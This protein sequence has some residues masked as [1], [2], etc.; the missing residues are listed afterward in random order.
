MFSNHGTE[1]AGRIRSA[2]AFEIYKNNISC[3]NLNRFPGG[4][5][6]GSTLF[7][8]NSIT[9]CGGG[10]AQ[11]NLDPYRM[12]NSFA[13]FGGGDGTNGWDKN[14]AGNPF[15][16]GTASAVGANTVSVSG[17]PGQP[18]NG[19]IHRQA[20]RRRLRIHPDEHVEH[21]H[22]RERECLAR[23][24]STL[25][26]ASS[27]TRLSS[28]ST[29]PVGAST[30]ISGDNLGHRTDGTWWP[31]HAIRGVIRMTV[32]P[33]IISPRNGQYQSWREFL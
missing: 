26:M 23:C 5:R 14:N 19:R 29:S 25:A 17:R 32:R 2:R 18:T 33:S 4:S 8:D 27:S 3:N 10:V 13:L 9:N 22:L 30:L 7:H 28:P 16:S 12:L 20:Q 15:Y 6:G 24:R 31:I 1:S 21:H 11:F